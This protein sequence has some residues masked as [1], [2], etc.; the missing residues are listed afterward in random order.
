MHMVDYRLRLLHKASF[1]TSPG[2]RCF[3]P[4]KLR[5]ARVPATI[6]ILASALALA[7]AA[8]VPKAAPTATATDTRRN[9]DLPLAAWPSDT[10][11]VAVPS[12]APV[13]AP[14]RLSARDD[15]ATLLGKLSAEQVARQKDIEVWIK[16]LGSVND[17]QSA[18]CQSCPVLVPFRA[19]R[20]FS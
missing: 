12:G 1:S 3:S 4:V 20:F 5:A 6:L 19:Q 10:P 11:K 13:R 18:P 9:D 17:M 7:L 8:A 2:R 16:H 14:H 15:Y